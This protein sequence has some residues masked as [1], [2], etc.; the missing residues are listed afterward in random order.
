MTTPEFRALFH[1]GRDGAGSPPSQLGQVL[2]GF[3][4]E[5]CSINAEIVD[6]NLTLCAARLI[7]SYH[8]G[9]NPDL[10][11]ICSQM[12]LSKLTRD[13]M[14]VDVKPNA[15]ELIPRESQVKPAP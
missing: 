4:F 12:K 14:P 13:R 15:I 7:R 11:Q 6:Q 10:V 8:A 2:D 3:L 9:M 1:Q 5:R